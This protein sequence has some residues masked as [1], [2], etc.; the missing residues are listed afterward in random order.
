M[1]RSRSPGD[2]TTLR[3]DAS[4]PITVVDAGMV[5]YATAWAWQ[6]DLARRRLDGEV[7][8]VVL[9]VQHPPT[10]TLG[11]R[12]DHDHVL[13]DEAALDAAGITVFEVDRGGDVTYHGPGQLVGYPVVRLAGPRVVDYVRALEE[14]NIRM[15]A[16]HD[17]T[18]TRIDG[19]TG[20]WTDRG[21]VTAIGVR[22]TAGRITQH[23][24]ATNVAPDLA[25]FDGIIACG[26]TDRSVTSMRALGS[27]ASMDT[28]V[29]DTADTVAAV[30][31]A[32]A[33]MA[34]PD[35]VGLH[36]DMAAEATRVVG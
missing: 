16:R 22:V 11:R 29:G 4:D 6:R 25:D 26:I 27:D 12:A 18:A 34:R 3:N 20:V 24:W 21:K 32:Q 36:V 19:L 7:G 15:L 17:I 33:I 23:G 10:Y 35:D 1:T 9:L 28:V 13:L 31:G 5:D 14:V 30:L 2:P 8:D